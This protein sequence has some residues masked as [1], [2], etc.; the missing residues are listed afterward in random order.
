MI[1]NVLENDLDDFIPKGIY[2]TKSTKSKYLTNLTKTSSN[3]VSKANQFSRYER[4]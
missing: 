1:V 3:I 4:K 2:K